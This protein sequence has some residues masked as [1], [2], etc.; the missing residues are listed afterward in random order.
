MNKWASRGSLRVSRRRRPARLSTTQPPGQA[1]V[2]HSGPSPPRTHSRLPRA[3]ALTPQQHHQAGA[4]HQPRAQ[5]VRLPSPPP[6]PQPHVV[7]ARIGSYLLT[8]RPAAQV[9][10]VSTASLAASP[11]TSDRAGRPI[12]ARAERDRVGSPRCVLSRERC[13]AASDRP[14]ASRAGDARLRR[15]FHNLSMTRR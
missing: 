14:D 3:G 13:I 2:R 7:T 12:A 10:R 6:E 11:A 1:P 4:R 8:P 15:N 5:A 9:G